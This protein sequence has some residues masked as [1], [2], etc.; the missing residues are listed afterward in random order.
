M[1]ISVEVS[2]LEPLQGF[3]QQISWEHLEGLMT[4][5]RKMKGVFRAKRHSS[6]LTSPEYFQSHICILFSVGDLAVVSIRET[7]IGLSIKPQ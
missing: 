5:F 2:F 1:L 6:T 7:V 4:L 3:S